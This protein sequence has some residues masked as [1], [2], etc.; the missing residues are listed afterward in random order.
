MQIKV[1]NEESTSFQ[2]YNTL[3]QGRARKLLNTFEH[4]SPNMR[5]VKISRSQKG[6]GHV[7]PHEQHRHARHTHGAA[8]ELSNEKTFDDAKLK[9]SNKASGPG[10]SKGSRSGEPQVH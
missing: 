10:F 6:Q 7:Y 4:T 3:I 9:G 1:C 8:H 5:H 2:N